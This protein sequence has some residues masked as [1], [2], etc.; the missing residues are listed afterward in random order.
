[1]IAYCVL[2]YD[3]G[4]KTKVFEDFDAAKWFANMQESLGYLPIQI[5]EANVE[6][7]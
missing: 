3:N 4:E 6:Y 1:M 7:S 2:W 5:Y